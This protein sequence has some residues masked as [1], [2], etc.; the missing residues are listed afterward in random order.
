MKDLLCLSNVNKWEA[1]RHL[2]VISVCPDNP[3]LAGPLGLIVVCGL[4]LDQSVVSRK[5]NRCPF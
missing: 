2:T 4:C 5:F 1:L 3:L